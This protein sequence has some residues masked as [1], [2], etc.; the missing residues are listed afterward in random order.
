MTQDRYI[1]FLW[2]TNSVEHISGIITDAEE[3][4]SD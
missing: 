2:Q 3:N 1:T 4:G